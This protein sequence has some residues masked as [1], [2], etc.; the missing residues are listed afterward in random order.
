MRRRLMDLVRSTA[1][2]LG[3]CAGARPG[4]GDGEGVMTKAKKGF[5][6]IAVAVVLVGF[7]IWNT[8]VFTRKP[9][10]RPTARDLAQNQCATLA[11]TNYLKAKVTLYQQHGSASL[12]SIDQVIAGRRLQEQYCLQFAT[13]ELPEGTPQVPP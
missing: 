4:N 11:L 13:C 2:P 10:L 12:Q 9:A 7:T 6:L 3:W 5:C 8:G 1:K